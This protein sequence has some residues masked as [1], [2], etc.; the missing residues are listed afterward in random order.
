[1]SAKDFRTWAATVLAFRALRAAPVPEREAQAKRLM[2]DAIGEVADRLGNTP[3]VARASYVDPSVIEAWREGSLGR[4]RRSL[5]EEG[6]PSGPPT[7]QEEAMVLRLLQR[8]R[9]AARRA[10]GASPAA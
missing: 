6:V 5:E 8:Q 7:E 10:D 2:V 9:R 3:A 1:V 4:L